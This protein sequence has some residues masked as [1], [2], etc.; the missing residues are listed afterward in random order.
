MEAW[1]NRNFGS[2]NTLFILKNDIYEILNAGWFHSGS[3][4]DTLQG[5]NGVLFGRGYVSQCFHPRNQ[6]TVLANAEETV[7]LFAQ[8]RDRL[9]NMGK[10]F[11]FIMAPGKAAVRTD[12]LPPIWRFREI[13]APKTDVDMTY[14]LWEETLQSYGIVYVNGLDE[15]RE[16]NAYGD[17]FPDTGTHWS[18]LGA[19]FSLEKAIS[20]LRKEGWS[21]PSLAINGSQETDKDYAAEKDIANTLNIYPH[22]NRGRKSWKMAIFAPISPRDSLSTIVLGDSFSVQL[23]HNLVSSGFSHSTTKIENRIPSTKEWLKELNKAEAL[24]FVYAYANLHQNRMKNETIRLLTMLDELILEDWHNYEK[25]GKGQWSKKISKATFLNSFGGDAEL[26]F[27]IKNRFQ[28][29]KL[30]LFLNG[31]ELVT[32]DLTKKKFPAAIKVYVPKEAMTKGLNTIEFRSEGAISPAVHTPGS[33]G[34]DLRT[35]GVFC[36]EFKIRP[37]KSGRSNKPLL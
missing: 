32:I 16:R 21:L 3:G 11:S 4:G 34:G 5:M 20:S 15:I 7:K 10:P 1:W 9:H 2:R 36:N 30:G 35:L 37:V 29:K 23:S 13:F 25:H 8:L 28:T 12:V 18:R 33:G 26:S 27:C 31:Y 14:D 22:Y 24:F 6:K 17:S 19:A